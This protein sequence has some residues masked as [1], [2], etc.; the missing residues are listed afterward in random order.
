MFIPKSTTVENIGILDCFPSSYLCS[1]SA[2]Y[3]VRL[4]QLKGY[5]ERQDREAKHRQTRLL[6]RN[7]KV[8]VAIS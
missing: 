6:T 3:H 7:R 1:F 5:E 8:R 2:R 4:A